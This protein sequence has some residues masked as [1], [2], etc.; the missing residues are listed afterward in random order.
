MMSERD[1][2]THAHDRFDFDSDRRLF[3]KRLAG[4]SAAIG[5]SG[6]PH[7]YRRRRARAQAPTAASD[8]APPPVGAR[9][10][11]GELETVLLKHAS[12]SSAAIAIQGA[13]VT[14]WKRAN[15]EEMLFVS[16]NS[17][18]VPWPADPWWDPGHLPAVRGARS[19]CRATAS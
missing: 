8:D 12:G 16:E 11:V 9:G 15:G 10:R 2:R 14:S 3:L 17:P 1:T 5:V 13:Q 7:A 19:R 4:A 6:S 18:L